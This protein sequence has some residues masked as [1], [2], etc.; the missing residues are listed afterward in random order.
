MWLRYE[1][2]PRSMVSAGR[3]GEVSFDKAV[4]DV[5][6]GSVPRG[7]LASAWWVEG[8]GDQAAFDRLFV[9]RLRVHAAL[10]FRGGECAQLRPMTWSAEKYP[11]VGEEAR[12]EPEPAG[13]GRVGG[14]GWH[15]PE[16]WLAA[17]TRTA[18]ERGV[19]KEGQLFTRRAARKDVVFRGLLQ[20][21][22]DVSTQEL[23]WLLRRRRVSVG[24]QL[25]VLGRCEWRAERVEN[26]FPLPS[27][28]ECIELVALQPIILL[29]EVGANSLDLESAI[30]AVAGRVGG[31]VHVERVATRPVV[32]GGW[33]GRAG[34]PK[35]KEWALDA[36]SA[37]VFTADE[38]TLAAL[39]D[40]LGVRRAEGFGAVLLHV[41]DE[42]ITWPAPLAPERAADEPPAPAA[43]SRPVV[44][45]RTVRDEVAD[46]LDRVPAEKREAVRSNLRD[47]A[48]HLQGA[49]R[50]PA[51]ARKSSRLRQEREKPWAKQLP[52]DVWQDILG[53]FKRKDFKDVIVA[54]EGSK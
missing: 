33:H 40:G 49:L 18:L 23:D 14:R 53:L 43:A 28:G 44:E 3:G 19:A 24:G 8:Q 20:V 47:L 42:P 35:P 16:G 32:V 12:F 21:S 11:P 51:A 17:T 13:V 48:R 50:G 27:S 22:D 31:E 26:P 29:D 10:P 45:Q 34:I 6:P 38:Q 46:I 2:R 52:E 7:A 36:G 4:H 1:L 30:K 5:L 39:A 54:L 25:S 9:R 37:A 41:A 15:V